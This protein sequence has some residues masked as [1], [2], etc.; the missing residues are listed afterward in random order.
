MIVEA[1][2]DQHRA[3]AHAADAVRR[4]QRS[5][6]EAAAVVA[7][8]QHDRRVVARSSRRSTASRRRGARRWSAPPARR[9]R[10]TSSCSCESGRRAVPDAAGPRTC[11]W[12]PNGGG[13]RGQRALQPEILERLGSQPARDPADVLGARGAPSR[14]AR[15][16]ARAARR[17]S[18]PAR[19]STW[20]ITPV[21][22]WPT[23][24]CSSRAI[25]RR[26]PSC[27]HQRPRARCRAARTPAGRASR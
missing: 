3:L 26:S 22:V 16:A 8:G 17:G 5:G 27:T 14:A 23:S 25:R 19:P 2:A 11:A 13:E 15:R 18:R 24:S 10:S 12:S 4:G 9:G 7:H 21:S 6:C 20:S 1:G